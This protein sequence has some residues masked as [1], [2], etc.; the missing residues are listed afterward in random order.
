MESTT[1]S[2]KNPESSKEIPKA[3]GHWL[4]GS[5]KE[6]QRSTYAWP[7]EFARDMGGIAQFRLMHRKLIAINDPDLYDHVMVR[8]HNAYERSFHFKNQRVL[9]GRGMISTD[10]EEWAKKKARGAPAFNR[11]VLKKVVPLST[12]TTKRFLEG[13]EL[14]AKENRALPLMPEIQMLTISIIS[15]AL[16]SVDV[17]RDKTGPICEAFRDAGWALRKRNTAIIPLPL[18]IPTPNNRE[19]LRIQ[20]AMAKFVNDKMEAR[21]ELKSQGQT[22]SDILDIVTRSKGWEDMSSKERDELIGDCRTLLVAGFETTA[23]TLTWALYL[24]SRHPEVAKKWHEE[25][26]RVLQGREPTWEDLDKLTYT[27]QIALETMR[28]YPVVFTQPRT[29]IQEDVLGGFRIK[30]GSILLL[31]VY[32]MQ[33]LKKYWDR[34][35]EFDPDR[36]AEGREWPKQAYMPFGKGKHTCIGN[37]M[38]IY[39]MQVILSMIG[40]RFELKRTDSDE[41]KIKSTIVLVPEREIHFIPRKRR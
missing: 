25:C 19:L 33:R 12:G 36:F 1:I 17:D 34:P 26:D 32:G 21:Q 38:A 22:T 4:W 6:F 5:I 7:G 18:W 27:K 30:K 31:S 16:F 23:L 9:F 8:N 15:Q 28:L 40:N 14:A 41:V 24:L 2:L 20:K 35:D 3:Q 11:D 29:C 13:W 37:N 39:E 10:G